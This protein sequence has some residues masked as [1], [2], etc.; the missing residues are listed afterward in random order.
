VP[1]HRVILTVEEIKSICVA[2]LEK[3][4]P[5][6]EVADVAEA[7]DVEDWSLTEMQFTLVYREEGDTPSDDNTQ[8]SSRDTDHEG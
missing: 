5:T 7:Y 2:H 1:E 6:L 3:Q 8:G 4:W